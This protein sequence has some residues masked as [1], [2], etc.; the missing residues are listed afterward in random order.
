M[1]L[2]WFIIAFFALVM[3]S[4]FFAILALLCAVGSMIDFFKP[5]HS[6]AADSEDISYRITINYECEDK[7]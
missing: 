1:P 3:N 6:P 4:K 5:N 7:E 2:L